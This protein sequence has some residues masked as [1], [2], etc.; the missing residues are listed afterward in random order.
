M[1]IRIVKRSTGE[2]RWRVTKARGVNDSRGR[3]RLVVSV[4]ED[5][6]E[7]KR[8]ELTQRV[9]SRTGQVLASSLDYEQTLREVAGLAVPDLAD[10]CGV[11]MPDRQGVIRQVAVVHSDP[12]K[13]EFAR[14][15][16]R[17]YP[18]HVS[19][20]GG[21]A[22]VLRDGQAQL[23]P[24]IP[25]EMLEQAVEDP[26][27]LELIRGLGMRSAVTAPMV[28]ATGPPMGVISFVNAESGRVFTEADLELLAGDR[29]PGGH[30]G[31]ERAA[32][33]GALDDR[34]HAAARAAA[35]RAAGD[36]RL[37]ARHALPARRGGRTG[38][39]A[40]STTRSRCR[41]AGWWWSATSPAA[42]PQRPR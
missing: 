16:G 35:A 27:Q 34:P 21:S 18:N 2:E 4:I 6:T 12:A 15:L 9:L 22:Q 13:V 39:A 7:R 24:E 5:I 37:R 23:I 25:D 20:E 14:D 11:S 29:A 28:A 36:P 33:R 3:P 32:V 1:T 19:D 38:S 31:R 17:R 40:T 41:A 10:W 30:R 42:A 26:E 8:S